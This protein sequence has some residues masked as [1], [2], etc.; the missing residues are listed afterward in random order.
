MDS[1]PPYA[2]ATLS[3]P[4]DAPP[5]SCAYTIE[6]AAV[7]LAHT[8]Q[9][10][11]TPIAQ[12]SSALSRLAH[13]VGHGA[14]VPQAPGS[15]SG[16]GQPACRQSLLQDVHICIESLQFHDRL[17]QQLVRVQ[18]LLG[19]LASNALLAQVPAAPASEGSIELF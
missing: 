12:L 13:A 11:E 15:A 6:M 4:D 2:A 9:Q 16:A 18:Q 8:M 10:S 14:S 7:L 3:S 19:G 5:R 1:A 17:M